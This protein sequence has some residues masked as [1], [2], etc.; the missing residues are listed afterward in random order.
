M[1]HSLPV[2]TSR[3]TLLGACMVAMSLSL[4]A[5]GGMPQN[6]LLESVHQPEVSHQNFALDLTTS[7]SGLSVDEAH[8]LDGWL[9]AMNLRYGDKVAIDD[10]AASP[11]TRHAIESVVSRYGVLLGSSAPVTPGYVTPGSLRVVLTRASANVPHCPDWA[12]KSETNFNNAT[13]HNYGC[14]V[15]SN[16][17]AMIANPDDLIRGASA[18]GS[19]TTQTGD[20]AVAAYR[21][22]QPTG[23]GNTVKTTSSKGS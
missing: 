7:P 11:E 1:I 6:R 18:T 15:N 14:A 3:K 19:T 23:G 8:R 17:A 5:C 10:P 13:S 12:D 9:S 21:A 4:S 16:M 22:A 2:R 20:K